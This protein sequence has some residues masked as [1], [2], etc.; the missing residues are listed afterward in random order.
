MG[1]L[2]PSL[3]KRGVGFETILLV[4]VVAARLAKR[5][6]AAGGLVGGLPF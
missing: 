4:L 3:A 1:R 2:G 6:G 5:M